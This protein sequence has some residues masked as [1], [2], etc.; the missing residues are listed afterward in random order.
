MQKLHMDKPIVF[1]SFLLFVF[2]VF[3]HVFPFILLLCF[4]DFADLLFVRVP[5]FAC[6][7]FFPSLLILR[8]NNG[9]VNM[10]LALTLYG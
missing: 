3:Y 4:W 9:L 2:P 10:N 5:F 6:V 8:T 7:S 1:P